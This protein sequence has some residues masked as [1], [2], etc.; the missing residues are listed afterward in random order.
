MDSVSSIALATDGVRRDL[1]ATSV[2]G[3]ALD[4]HALR[5]LLHFGI[6]AKGTRRRVQEIISTCRREI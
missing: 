4:A 1:F 3:G 6:G 5:L 2:L